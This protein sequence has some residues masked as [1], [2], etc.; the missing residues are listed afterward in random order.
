[1]TTAIENHA[2]ATGSPLALLGGE[3]SITLAPNDLFTW[4]IITEE[5]EAAVLEV[6]RARAMSGTGVTMQFEKEFA[7]WMGV[8]YALGFNNGTSS[9][10]AAM[11][12]VGIG[13]GDEII[14]PATTYWASALPVY[15]LGATVVFADIDPQTLC[16]DPRDIEHRITP[17]TRAIVVVHYL[18]HPAE[19]DAIM[20]IANRHGLKV[21]EDVSHAQG[22]LYQGRRVGSFGHVSGYSLM[23]GKS[24]AVGEGGMLTT[25]DREIHDRALAFGH[26]ERYD[27][28]IA[29]ASLRPFAGLP[30]GGFKNRMH[31]LSSAVGRVQLRHYDRRCAEIRKARN[32][33]WELLEGVPGLHP[34][35]VSAASGSNMAGGYGGRGFYRTEELGGLSIFRFCEAMRAE[36]VNC[37]PGCNRPLHTHPIFN[38]ADIYQ[39]GRPTRIAHSDRDLRQKP[40]SLPVS[41]QVGNRVFTIPWF[42]HYRPEQIREYAEA[43]RKVAEHAD[44]LLADDPGNPSEPGQWNFFR[45]TN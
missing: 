7:Q 3:K 41:E 16:L 40:G 10:L 22:G 27:A 8:K 33:F 15:S 25:N 43:F 18:G 36:G 30:L 20:E 6:L 19:M 23:C 39:H 29:T 37:T 9:L 4:P 38:E 42:K 24:F 2:P 12:G 17:K 5:D 11:F 32:Y 34:H 26:Y 31:Q 13:Q 44:E 28:A 14:C 21:I 1:M 35:S 45:S